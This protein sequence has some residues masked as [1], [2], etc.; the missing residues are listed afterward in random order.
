[1]RVC[2]IAPVP[3]F[4]GGIA[5]YCHS[6]AKEL[7][8]RHE[9]LL[10][11]YKRQYPELLFGRKSQVDPDVDR[12]LIISGF[13]RLSFGIDSANPLS[14]IETSQ[15]I[16]SFKPDILILP[17]WVAYWA[18]MY[19]YLIHSMKKK[20]IKVV[21]LC[22]NVFEH[23]DNSFKKYLTKFILC[24]VHY[25]IVHSEQEKIEILEFNSRA[26][27]KKHLLPLFEYDAMPAARRDKSLNLLFFGF[28]RPYK[29]LDTLLKAI[30][31][32][33]NQDISLRIAGEFWNDKDDYVRLIR[34]QD[35][36]DKVEIIDG[37]LSDRDMS[38][39]FSWA[40]LVVLPYRKSLTSGIIAT[41]YGFRKPVLA[42]NVGG[43]YEVIQDGCTGKIVPA[44]DPKSL[45]DG[46]LWF[47][48]NK[49][50]D[51]SENISTFASQNMSWS[52]LVDTIEEYN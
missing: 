42:T 44:D 5:K 24:R 2:L 17:W 46:I 25:F 30:G 52:S 19:L 32:L 8:K 1:M 50:I 41:A 3:P 47:L 49:Q 14:W 20:G 18:P 12:A 45:A 7:E 35:I 11:S 6:L 34:D 37:Y 48:T 36:A 51:F 26:T 10:L 33:R 21:F 27:I 15:K 29:G 22:I 39:C 23:E 13:N 9:L 4:R 31:I 28:V 38:L 16:A 40:D 43:F